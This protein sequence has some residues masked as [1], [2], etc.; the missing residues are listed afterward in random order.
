MRGS[1]AA[2]GDE[3]LASPRALDEWLKRNVLTSHH[4][5]GTARMGPA[6]DPNAVVD[7]AGRVHGVDGLRVVDASIMPDC[8]RVNINAT[9]MMVASRI[10]DVMRGRALAA[11]AVHARA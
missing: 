10:A 9:T 5:C 6:S 3:D 7:G 1:R 8:P 11:A 4:P 2:P